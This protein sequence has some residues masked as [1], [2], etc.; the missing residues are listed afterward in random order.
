MVTPSRS[1]SA[2]ALHLV[3][4]E[5]QR[6][7]DAWDAQLSHED[8]SLAQ[9][10][11]GLCLRR[12]GRLM[13]YLNPRL[14]NPER[15]I[16]LGS[17]VALAQGLAQLAWLPGVGTHAA[18]NESVE[19]VANRELGFPPHRGLVNAILRK[20]SSDREAL[21]A[22]L[23]ALS[24]ALDRSPWAERILKGA[25][26]QGEGREALW[27]RLQTPPSPW[28]RALA[29]G[30]L[31][32]GLERDPRASEA[33]RILPGAPFPR[34]WLQEGRGMVQD[35]S[36]QALMDFRWEAPVTRILDACAAP[37]GKTTA[38]ARRF[39]EA[40]LFAL[41]QEPRRAQRL[42]DNLAARGVKA[43]V[44]VEEAG[45]WMAKGGRPFDL[46]LLDAP[47]SGSGTLQKHPELVWLGHTVDLGRLQSIQARLLDQALARL[48]P[49]GLLIYAVCSWLPEEGE[50]QAK[51]LLARHPELRP[52]QVWG[53]EAHFRP[54][55]LEWPGEGFQGYAFTKA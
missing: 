49:G 12:W 36:S 50:A 43:Q 14:K 27:S 37:G 18:V 2:R 34:T 35:L 11:L 6:V 5:G 52:A 20:A 23:E 42:K 55:P 17:Q 29:T 16:P 46:I 48:A 45:A 21:K 13:A 54:D 40:T 22:E 9:A 30:P 32:E 51:A 19:L 26:P 7:P 4:G 28:F 33:L 47:C 1:A 44:M 3:F 10:I 25:L 41:E 53:P 39:P 8:A 15:G 31:P 24:P 38:L